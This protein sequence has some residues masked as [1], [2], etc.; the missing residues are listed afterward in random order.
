[1]I[2]VK[3]PYFGQCSDL[4]VN[5]SSEIDWKVMMNQAKE[6]SLDKFKAKVKLEEFLKEDS[7]EEF[8]ADDPDSKT[9]ESV[10]DCEMCC[11]LQSKGFEFIFK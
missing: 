4:R 6:I 8:I 1:M 9:F 7:L 5:T 3:Y 10:W 11:F 2:E